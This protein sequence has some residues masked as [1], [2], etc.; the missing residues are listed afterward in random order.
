M[1]LILILFFV[2]LVSLQKCTYTYDQTNVFES[3]QCKNVNSL[4]DFGDEIQGNWTKVD[5]INKV[6]LQ[7]S[8]TSGMFIDNLYEHYRYRSFFYYFPD[9]VVP[10]LSA[11]RVLN[12]SRA[13][14]LNISDVG[15]KDY[16][17]L[18]VLNV[19]NTKIETLKS[20]W[21][22]R[23]TIEVLNVSKNN[24]K[25]LKKD[26]FKYF[27]KLNSLNL[28]YNAIDTIELYAFM[29]LKNL[30]TLSLSNNL[31]NIVYFSYIQNLKYL[32]LRDN[33][34]TIVC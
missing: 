19:S 21:F 12:L 30:E 24:I 22:S 17:N 18:K 34:I 10:N 14:K 26:D 28:S 1:K 16:E 15:F 31:L 2:Q 29:D 5:I 32:Y 13:G 9:S 25:A 33:S 11:I 23:K 3:V 6:G 4:L 27:T 7:F 20:S 8:I